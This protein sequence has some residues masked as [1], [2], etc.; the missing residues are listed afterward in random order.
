M[1][2][3]ITRAQF[4]GELTRNEQDYAGAWAGI[5]SSEARLEMEIGE[6]R[7]KWPRRPVTGRYTRAGE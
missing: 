7:H 6:F 3:S 4:N 1:S 5:Q 2:V